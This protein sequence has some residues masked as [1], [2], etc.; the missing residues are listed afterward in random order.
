MYIA[1]AGIL[2]RKISYTLLITYNQ[3]PYCEKK[4]FICTCHMQNKLLIYLVYKDFHCQ[5]EKTAQYH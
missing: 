4:I 2:A 3:F 1:N 5:Y